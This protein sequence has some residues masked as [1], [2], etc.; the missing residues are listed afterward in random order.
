L[1]NELRSALNKIHADDTLKI[2]TARYLETKTNR[3]NQEIIRHRIRLAAVCSAF[4]LFILIGGFSYNLYFAPTAYVDVDV[5]PSIGLTLNRFNR[6]IDS[7]AYND[8]GEVVLTEA[9]IRFK[10]YGEAIK[11][12]LDVIISKGYLLEEGLVSVTV[13]ADDGSTEND[14]LE[15]LKQAVSVSLSEH[16]TNAQADIF[17]VTNDV[18][19]DAREHHMTPAKYLAISELQTVDPTATFEAC[20]EHSI[21]EIRESISSH[22]GGHH[23]GSESNGGNPYSDN[24]EE[25]SDDS[26]EQFNEQNNGHHGSDNHHR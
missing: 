26:T 14:M 19:M 21:S 15:S 7:N 24:V 4:L 3:H 20:A 22:G 23:G 16:H 11:I 10:T 12:L 8:D 17:P 9:N 6:V 18:R 13:Q 5:N 25:N 1:E 2:R